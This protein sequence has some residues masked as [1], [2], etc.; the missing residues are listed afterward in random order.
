[1]LKLVYNIAHLHAKVF[2]AKMRCVDKKIKL[3][4]NKSDNY[5]NK[6]IFYTKRCIDII[7]NKNNHLLDAISSSVY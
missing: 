4:L 6:K 2:V 1:M 5:Y 3:K 7:K